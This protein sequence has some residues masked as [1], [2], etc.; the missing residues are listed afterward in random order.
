VLK[1]IDVN[2]VILAKFQTRFNPE[3]S[4]QK[5]EVPTTSVSLRGW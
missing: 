2:H 5:A 1:E 4:Q 3:R